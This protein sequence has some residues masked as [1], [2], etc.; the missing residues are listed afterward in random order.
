MISDSVVPVA[1][2]S[3]AFENLVTKGDEDI[4]GL[5]AY[6]LFKQSVR[7]ATRGGDTSQSSERN[8]APTSVHVYR[9]AAERRLSELVDFAVEGARPQIEASA[10]RRAIQD[11][12][13]AIKAHVDQRTG[14]WTAVLAGIVAWSLSLLVTIVIIW[15]SGKGDAVSA[16]LKG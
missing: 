11:G 7:E 1:P 8:P 16:L 5:L 13:V 6:A 3:R 15:L 9:S 12:E 4:V 2:F 14:F 10:L